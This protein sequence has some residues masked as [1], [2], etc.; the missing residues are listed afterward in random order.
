[1]VVEQ[2]SSP[3]PDRIM[4]GDHLAAADIPRF[5]L[6]LAAVRP[7]PRTTRGEPTPP[8]DPL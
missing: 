1:M 8:V 5:G 2:G 3:F 4:T 6:N 7:D